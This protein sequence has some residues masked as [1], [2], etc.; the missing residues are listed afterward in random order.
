MQC[1]VLNFSKTKERY[2]FRIDSEFFHPKFLDLD[3]KI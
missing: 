3:E 2:D 1:S